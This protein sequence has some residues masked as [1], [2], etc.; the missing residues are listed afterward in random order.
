MSCPGCNVACAT[1]A[2]LELHQQVWH[3]QGTMFFCFL[4]ENRDAR[5]V[6]HHCADAPEC[7]PTHQDAANR[8]LDQP[9][10]EAARGQYVPF[11]EA[12]DEGNEAMDDREDVHESSVDDGFPRTWSNRFRERSSTSAFYQGLFE[13]VD[14]IYGNACKPDTSRLFVEDNIKGEMNLLL[15]LLR[16][17]NKVFCCGCS[18]DSRHVLPLHSSRC[19]RR[20]PAES[21]FIDS[22]ILSCFPRGDRGTLGPDLAPSPHAANVL[23]PSDNGTLL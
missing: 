13:T 9:G 1:A 16:N 20:R 3:G 12:A 19:Q 8:F 22:R 7:T 11:T 17:E 2:D 23:G 4:C 15:R 10:G 18:K 21:V 14:D 6:K 5:S